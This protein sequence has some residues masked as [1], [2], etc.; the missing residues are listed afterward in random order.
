MHE[1]AR[2]MAFRESLV[3]RLRNDLRRECENLFALLVNNDGGRRFRD[4]GS[5]M[6]LDYQETKVR[7]LLNELERLK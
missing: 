3:L 5:E 7:L 4:E 6:E 1:S 2:S